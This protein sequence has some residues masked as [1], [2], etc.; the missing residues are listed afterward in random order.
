MTKEVKIDDTAPIIREILDND[1]TVSFVPM[2]RSMYP[3]LT[4]SDK[5]VIGK[6]SK[7]LK[8]YDLPFYYRSGSN[9]YVIHRV[10]GFDNNGGYVMCGD[11]QLEKEYGIKDSDIIGIVVGFYRKNKYHSVSSMSYK[12]YCRLV[13]A[14]R[15]CHRI[16]C[17]FKG[18]IR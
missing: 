10:V 11:F 6:F 3:L 8:K 9:Q 2:G 15:L 18:I 5:V 16:Y 17:F 13:P 1:G 4:G 12:I 7:P 14:L